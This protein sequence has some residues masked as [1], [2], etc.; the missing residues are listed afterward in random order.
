MPDSDR[1]NLT[2]EALDD[3]IEAAA[4][5]GARKALAGVGLHD[6]RAVDDVRQLRD[7]LKM[8][9]VVRNS[10]LAALGKAMMYALIGAAALW[11]GIKYK[12]GGGS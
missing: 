8:Y 3:V 11:L 9:R 10:A 12:I 2:K 5:R 1:I 4:E 6:E 7:L